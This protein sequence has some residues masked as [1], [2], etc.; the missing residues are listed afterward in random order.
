MKSG[1]SIDWSDEALDNLDSIIEYLQ[2]KWTD[3][4]ISRFFKKLDKH[5]VLLSNNSLLFP[6]VDL[7]TN[8]RRSILTQQTTIY[9]QIKNNIVLLFSPFSITGKTRNRY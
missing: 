5:I 7:T 1:Y 3:M 4:Q 6:V 9:Y 2:N 8:L